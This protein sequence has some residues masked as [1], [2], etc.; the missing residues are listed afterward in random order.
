ME[1]LFQVLAAGPSQ[2]VGTGQGL[3]TP[4]W[5]RGAVGLLPGD[6]KEGAPQE[7]HRGW[8]QRQWTHSQGY[9]WALWLHSSCPAVDLGASVLGC[10]F[11]E[12]S[13]R[14]QQSSSPLLQGCWG[15]TV[16][17]THLR[18][19]LR[20]LVVQLARRAPSELREPRGAGGVPHR[21]NRCTALVSTA[22]PR[23]RPREGVGQQ[24]HP[25]LRAFVPISVATESPGRASST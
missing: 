11:P 3:C 21:V 13:P 19:N 24:D 7:E 22:P 9:C 4:W 10:V 14:Q 20:M 16:G 2:E 18:H 1:R 17:V 23:V 5:E 15:G 6:D 8:H 25:S 12:K